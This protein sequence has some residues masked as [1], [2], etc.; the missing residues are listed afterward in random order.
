MAAEAAIEGVAPCSTV[1]LSGTQ[2]IG[3][4][5]ARYLRRPAL[6]G[7]PISGEAL[8][9]PLFAHKGTISNGKAHLFGSNTAFV[10]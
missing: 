6:R 4:V 9:G 8:E 2:V 7:S 1:A 10:D 5:L 3:K